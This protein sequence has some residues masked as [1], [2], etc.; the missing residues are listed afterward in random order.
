VGIRISAGRRIPLRIIVRLSDEDTEKVD[1]LAERWGLKKSD[2]PRLTI[3]RFA[4]ENSPANK[5]APFD[6]VESLVGC[7]ESGIADLENCQREHL[8]KKL[9]KQE[10]DENEYDREVRLACPLGNR[11]DG[12][13]WV[14]AKG[15]HGKRTVLVLKNLIFMAI[16]VNIPMDKRGGEYHAGERETN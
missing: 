3:R 11:V 5:K 4:E 16:P 1:L 9:R 2:I 6:R 10:T 12:L 14:S 13:I 8:L 7:G 15:A